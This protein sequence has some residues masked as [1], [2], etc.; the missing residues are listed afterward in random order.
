MDEKQFSFLQSVLNYLEQEHFYE[1]K[2]HCIL[3]LKKE[4]T[5]GKITLTAAR[6]RAGKSMGE[7]PFNNYLGALTVLLE[8]GKHTLFLC[9]LMDSR[10]I[11]NGKGPI[12]ASVCGGGSSRQWG[13]WRR[14][15]G[16]MKSCRAMVVMRERFSDGAEEK[17]CWASW[18][19][20][21]GLKLHWFEISDQFEVKICDLNIS[22][23]YLCN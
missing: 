21:P 14:E 6:T 22:V 11:W 5:N 15:G 2:T 13:S 9:C 16:K 17:R 20:A 23:T 4:K 19:K 1:S 12:C 8:H 18:R 10:Y 7:L 3:L